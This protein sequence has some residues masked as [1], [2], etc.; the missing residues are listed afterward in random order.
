MKQNN[1]FRQNDKKYIKEIH[2][3]KKKQEVRNLYLPLLLKSYKEWHK[4]KVE[5]KKLKLKVKILQK[6]NE[7]HQTFMC[8]KQNCFHKK[9]EI[10]DQEINCYS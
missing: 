10:I 6:E 7:K 8:K 2:T 9:I 4:M 1:E 3:L 5:N